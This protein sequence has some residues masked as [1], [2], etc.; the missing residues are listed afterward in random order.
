MW[1]G[2]GEHASSC[3]S[4]RSLSAWIDALEAQDESRWND[5]DEQQRYNEWQEQEEH[6]QH[7]QFLYAQHLMPGPLPQQNTDSEV[8]TPGGK[9]YSIKNMNVETKI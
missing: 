7:Q 9:K 4:H 5:S 8:E 1:A 2:P 6:E 3:F